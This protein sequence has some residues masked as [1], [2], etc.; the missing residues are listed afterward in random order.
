MA[1][2]TAPPPPVAGG[3][4]RPEALV[5]SYRRLAEVFHD[6]LSEQSLDALL[7][8][9][10]DTLSDLVPYE[11]ATIYEADEERRQLRPALARGQYSDEVMRSRPR[12]GEGLT[13]WAV[14][15]RRP[16]WTN[17]A[18]LDPRATTVEGTPEEPEAMIVVPLIARG[19]LKGALNIYRVGEDAAFFEH[20]FELATSFGDAAALALDNA[21]IRERLE[22][23]AQ[24]DGLTGLYNHRFFHERLRAELTRASR[25]HDSVAVLMFDLDDFKRVN[26]VYGHGAGDQLLVQIARLAR[27]EVRGSDVV[28][29]I[30]GEEFGVIMPSCDAGDALVLAS[31]LMERLR[32]LELEPMGRITLS[33]GVSQGPQHAMNPRE[34]VAC[35]EAAMMTA[36]ARGKNQVVLYDGA[37]ERPSPASVGRDIRSI[38]HLKMLQ[39]LAGK[40]NRLNDVSQIAETIATELRLLID[41]HNCRIYLREGESDLVPIAFVGD[42]EDTVTDVFTAYRTRVGQGITGRVVETGESMLVGN[43]NENELS[44][45]IPGTDDLEET[46]AAVPLRYGTRV[47]GAIVISKLGQNQFDED[48]VRLLEVLGGHASVALEN[49]RLYESQRREADGAKALLAFVDEVSHA[50]SFDEVC[51]K[52]VETAASLFRTDAA[53]LW[54][55]DESGDFGRAASVGVTEGVEGRVARDRVD[56]IIVER[57]EPFRGEAVIVAPLLSGDGVTGWIAV[58]KDDPIAVPDDEMRLLAAFSYQASVALQKATL[59]WKQQEAAEIAN[60]LLDASRQLATAENPADV[61]QRSVEVTARALATNNVSLWIEDEDAPHE[62]VARAA[63]GREDSLFEFSRFPRWLAH[64]WL[65]RDEPFIL[66]P[67]TLKR[68]EGFPPEK[69]GRFAIAP[70]HLDNNRVG[71][72]TALVEDERDFDD[73]QLRLLAGLAHQAKLAIES[74]DQYKKLERTFVSTV[75]ALANALEANDEYTS[76]H[77]RWITDMALLV[78]QKLELARDSL[79]RLELGALFHDIGKIGIPSEIL[80]KPGPLTDEEFTL[81]KEHPALGE[82]ILEPIDRLSD[83]RPIVRACHERWDGLG[84]PDG[85]A[86]EDIPIESRIVLV[87]DAYHAMVTDR[88]YRAALDQQEAVRRLREASG[89]QFDPEVVDAFLQLAEDGALPPI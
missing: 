62:L 22:Y 84:Y 58:A 12:F 41:Y 3:G 87:C 75:A 11:S 56:E 38:A 36:K 50:Q 24:T 80:R 81:L 2:G 18:H 4:D 71:A 8:R 57:R 33:V 51:R 39:S 29:R 42:F 16:V 25:Q 17:R 26:D 31:R 76:S 79:Q 34:L 61:L 5:Q 66:Q 68:I 9:I 55:G 54:L 35:A 19:I 48:D 60:A 32:S 65:E 10:A 13:G 40:L 52:T 86:G 37:S 88:P 72:L 53:S 44:Y 64:E 47:T 73:R 15:H 59:Y 14:V 69:I 85:K 77:A 83:V 78:G 43:A 74:G 6:V 21:Q 27:E 28:C 30:G 7:E 20:E 82:R 89:S 63:L 1:R 70:L 49:A 23:L 45:R 46:L 67:E